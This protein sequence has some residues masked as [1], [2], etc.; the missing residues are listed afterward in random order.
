MQGAFYGIGAAVIAIIARSAWKLTRTSL[1]HDYLL[2]SLFGFSALV[3]AWTESEIV[4]LFLLSGTAA[5]GLRARRP[6]AATGLLILPPWLFSGLL[7]A[8]LTTL[9]VLPAIYGVLQ[10]RASTKSPSLN[11]NDPESRYYVPN[12]A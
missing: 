7:A 9:T 1:G 5:M 11:P 8:T 4:W 12:P 10:R 2:W 3:T 6:M